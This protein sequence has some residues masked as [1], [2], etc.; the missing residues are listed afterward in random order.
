MIQYVRC[1]RHTVDG[2]R[3]S[4]AFF[5]TVRDR[6]VEIGG[7]QI[8]ET[9][10]DLL[11]AA[12]S[13][14]SMPRPVADLIRLIPPDPPLSERVYRFASPSDQYEFPAPKLPDHLPYPP[15]RKTSKP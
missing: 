8:F 4:F 11:D 6:F 13:E 5:D 1:Q 15:I 12:H 7:E 2:M 14:T 10:Q 3:E 9:I